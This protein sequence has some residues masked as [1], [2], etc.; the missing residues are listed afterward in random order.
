MI[1][2]PDHR[3]YVLTE[4]G[5]REAGIGARARVVAGDLEGPMCEF[6]TPASIRLRVLAQSVNAE[7]QV[8]DGSQSKRRRVTRITIDR[9]IEK[10]Q[11]PGEV[12]AR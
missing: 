9:L 1:D 7:P 12:L 4:I 2:E 6:S 10:A 11:R 3:A 8:A 5:E